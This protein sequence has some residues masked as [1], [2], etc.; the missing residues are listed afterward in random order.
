MTSGMPEVSQTPFPH[1]SENGLFSEEILDR[2][3]ECFPDD[4]SGP[5]IRYSESHEA[6]KMEMSDPS[7]WPPLIAEVLEVL[8]SEEMAARVG[9]AFGIPNLIGSTYGG[10]LHCSPRGARLAMHTDFTH[11]PENGLFRRI[12]MLLFLNKGWSEDQGGALYLGSEMEVIVPP[13]FNQ[14]GCFATS[15]ISAHGHPVPWDADNPRRSLAVYFYS[16]EPPENYSGPSST[17]WKGK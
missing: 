13:K 11:H 12:N 10:G 3:L 14:L 15:S 5:W 6:G 17:S 1:V 2:V 16:P 4:S 8:T 9:E 7:G